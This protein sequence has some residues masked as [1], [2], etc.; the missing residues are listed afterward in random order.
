M[1]TRKSLL[2]QTYPQSIPET[3]GEN[4]PQ[5]VM[6]LR[7][8]VNALR[9]EHYEFMRAMKDYLDGLNNP[10][11]ISITQ[12]AINGT[13]IG[14]L[15]PST[16]AF[17]TLTATGKVDSASYGEFGTTL[18]TFAK[19][20][21]TLAAG[22]DLDCTTAASGLLIVRNNSDGG[23]AVV[24]VELGLGT[25]TTI[26]D[27]S[28]YVAVGADPGAA[29]SKFWITTSG[30]TTIRLRNRYATTHLSVLASLSRC[31]PRHLGKHCPA[32]RARPQ[33]DSREVDR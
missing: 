17:T 20:N 22:A 19:S 30:G 4:I 27:P 29:S 28:G 31:H 33:A 12:A 3:V 8:Q 1:F 10:N 13:P 15:N 23:V 16:G 9:K 5:E 21:G 7:Q 18:T 32:H 6:A 14:S 24:S 25:C 2:L 26:S 11:S